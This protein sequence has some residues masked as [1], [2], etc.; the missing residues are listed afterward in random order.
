MPKSTKQLLSTPPAILSDPALR[1]SRVVTVDE[2][3]AILHT[4][5][6]RI[7]E[8]LGDGTIK[9]YKDGR[10]RRVYLYSILEYQR[11]LTELGPRIKK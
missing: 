3:R 4:G 5:V 6:E 7:Y 9:S 8:L 2:A 11:R 1:S 10:S